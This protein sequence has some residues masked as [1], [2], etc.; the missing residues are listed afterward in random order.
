LSRNGFAIIYGLEKETFFSR[1]VQDGRQLCGY[2]GY[3]FYGFV[4][5]HLEKA[6]SKP[7]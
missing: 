2:F 4:W 6:I 1:C 5:G 7:F 3:G